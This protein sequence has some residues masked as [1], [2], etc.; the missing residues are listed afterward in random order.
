MCTTSKPS[1]KV[2]QKCPTFPFQKYLDVIHP[3]QVIDF[4]QNLSI[5]II[6]R[7]REKELPDERKKFLTNS[8]ISDII[9]TKKDKDSPKNQ[10]GYYYEESHHD[11]YRELPDRKPALCR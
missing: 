10:K 6:V 5:I 1:E 7:G 11:R 4:Y 2:G 9:N 8:K 3:S